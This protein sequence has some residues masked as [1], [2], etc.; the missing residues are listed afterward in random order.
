MSSLYSNVNLCYTLFIYILRM[1]H[2]NMNKS[3]VQTLNVSVR[4]QHLSAC[5]PSCGK[6]SSLSVLA[7]RTL[8]TPQTVFNNNSSSSYNNNNSNHN[9]KT[10]IN[11]AIYSRLR[12]SVL[13]SPLDSESTGMISPITAINS[14]L[15]NKPIL[16]ADVRHGKYRSKH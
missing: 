11:I 1:S 2:F 4:Y 10:N 12:I 13:F 3:K 16:I 15:A 9:N 14:C 5:R 7:S 6:D 8:K